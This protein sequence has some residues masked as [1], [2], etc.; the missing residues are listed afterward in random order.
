MYVEGMQRVCGEY[1]KGMIHVR[2]SDNIGKT[3]LTQTTKYIEN[4]HY[5]QLAQGTNIES[6]NKWNKQ[7]YESTAMEQTNTKAQE[8]HT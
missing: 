2:Y 5:K 7:I 1:E 6:S 4:D 8:P 3:T